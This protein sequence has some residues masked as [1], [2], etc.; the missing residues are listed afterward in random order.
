[1]SEL[2]LIPDDD[3]VNELQARYDDILIIGRQ[4]L[5][6]ND[7]KTRRVRWCKGDP[8]V[9]IGMAFAVAKE[10]IDEQYDNQTREDIND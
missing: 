2:Q 5:N 8:D 4:V 6:K 1:M 3:L 10:N 9:I 7:K